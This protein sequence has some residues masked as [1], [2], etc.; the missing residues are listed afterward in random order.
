MLPL[1][2]PRG[3]VRDFKNAQLEDIDCFTKTIDR[4]E[5]DIDAM[6]V[7]ANAWSLGDINAIRKLN[8]TDQSQSCNAAIFDSKWLGGLKGSADL[9][10]RIKTSWLTAAEKSLATN[11]STF[12]MLPMSDLLSP[13]G[14]VAAL[15]TRGYQID[16]PD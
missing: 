8:F 16:E 2:N 9:P 11:K 4:L 5:S 12:A 10:Q 13:D 6:K 15:R 7:R 1:E 14:L 3:A